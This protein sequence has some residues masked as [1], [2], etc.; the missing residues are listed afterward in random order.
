M[1]SFSVSLCVR[2][3][4]RKKKRK[5]M[6]DNNS[7]LQTAVRIGP[8]QNAQPSSA[9]WLQSEKYEMYKL[10]FTLVIPSLKVEM[11]MAEKNKIAIWKYEWLF[12]KWCV[13][14]PAFFFY[15]LMKRLRYFFCFQWYKKTLNHDTSSSENVSLCLIVAHRLLLLK[16]SPWRVFEIIVFQ[17]SKVW[18]NLGVW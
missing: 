11:I 3:K 7:D 1:I 12:A 13:L 8:G 17:Q 10:V 4:K 14:L 9:F 16:A 2:R 5:Q 6:C 15:F 18:K